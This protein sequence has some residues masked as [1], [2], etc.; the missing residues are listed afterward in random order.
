MAFA[1]EAMLTEL[2][3]VD[4]FK[5]GPGTVKK[6][7]TRLLHQYHNN[8]CADVCQQM[9]ANFSAAF[10][11]TKLARSKSRIDVVQLP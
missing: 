4:T 7:A 10:V 1:T 9:F 3:F 11:Y 8:P 5:I 6:F 2:N